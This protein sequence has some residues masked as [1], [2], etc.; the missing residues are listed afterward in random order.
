VPV[1]GFALFVTLLVLTELQYLQKVAQCGAGHLE[2]PSLID[3]H[4]I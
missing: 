2:L 3:K 4:F 1:P